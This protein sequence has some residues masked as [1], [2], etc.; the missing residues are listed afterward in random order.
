MAGL[1]SWVEDYVAKQNAALASIPAE[2]V[3]K[4][5]EYLQGA[6]KEDRQV[7]VAGNGGSAANASHFAVDLGKGASDKM[8]HRFRVTSLSD[9]TPWMTAIA[10]DYCYDDVFVRQ[11]ENFARAG[12]L[13][14][15]ISVSGNSPNL[16]KAAEWAKK[17][18]VIVV[19][20]AGA[21]R[22]RLA[23]VADFTIVVEDTHYGRVEDVQM[24]ILH[25]MC[26]AF[27]EHPALREAAI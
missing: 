6:W 25:M 14:I 24:H 1:K 13:L 12:D 23:E 15:L 9:N 4:V 11:M 20:L 10:N 2:G 26:Y 17:N 21:K 27:M 16:V 8:K 5:V 7:F 19:S 3:V 18:G 22:G